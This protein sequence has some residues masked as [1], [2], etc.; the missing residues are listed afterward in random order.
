MIMHG[1]LDGDAQTTLIELGV[2]FQELYYRKLKINLLERSKKD[3]ILIL[4]KLEKIFS[5]LFFDIVVHLAVH[6]PK[7]ALLTGSIYYRGCILLKDKKIIRTLSY[8]L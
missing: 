1:Y 3:I 2:F 5:S 6:L 4:C 8:Q 7:E